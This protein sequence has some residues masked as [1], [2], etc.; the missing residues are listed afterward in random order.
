MLLDVIASL[1]DQDLRK[2]FGGRLRELRKER[3]W[4][5]KELAARLGIRQTH[6]TK[7]ETGMHVPPLDK[8]IQLVRMFGVSLD[9]LVLG[10]APSNQPVKDTR[11]A[12]R[13]QALEDFNPHDRETVI[14]LIDAMVAR[15]RMAVAVNPFESSQP[16]ANPGA[17]LMR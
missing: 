16:T 13:F 17:P 5:Q 15:Q 11:L 3:G 1:Q 6:Y 12:Q 7:Y 8:V 2:A 14:T 9:R 4:T 10:E